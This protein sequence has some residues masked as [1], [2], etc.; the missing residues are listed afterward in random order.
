MD[1]LSNSSNA[2]SQIPFLER[3]SRSDHLGFK[4]YSSSASTSLSNTPVTMT[5]FNGTLKDVVPYVCVVPSNVLYLQQLVPVTIKIMPTEHPVSVVSAVIK[6]KQYTRLQVS[7]GTKSDSKE[8]MSFPVTDEW[9]V[10]EARKG[11][12]RTIVV[13]L[14]GVPQVTPTFGSDMITKTHML[15]LIMQVRMGARGEKHELRVEMP[16][17][18]TGPRPPGEPYPSFDLNRYL[19]CVDQT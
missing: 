16:V 1:D 11:W 19:A 4:H 2:C 12:Q 8:L 3:C 13:S 7:G 15:K 14:P 9:P 17:I 10:P 18:I 5:R 6:L